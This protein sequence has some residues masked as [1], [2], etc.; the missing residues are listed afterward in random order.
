MLLIR[1]ISV[2]S[3]ALAVVVM[4]VLM[5]ISICRSQAGNRRAP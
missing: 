2:T 5:S 4:G 3:P 1:L